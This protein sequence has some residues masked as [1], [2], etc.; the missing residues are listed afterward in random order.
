MESSDEISGQTAKP[1]K[2]KQL[3]DYYEVELTEKSIIVTHPQ[4]PIEQIDW[5]DIEE[6]RLANTDE[7]PFLPD[8]WMILTGNGKAC[9]IP[10]GSEG[11]DKVYNIVSK[12]EGFSFENVIKSATCADNQFFELWKRK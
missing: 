1:P 6:I 4:R 7:G 3:E 2:E 8:V 12:Y 11:R 10:Q 5:S 9:S